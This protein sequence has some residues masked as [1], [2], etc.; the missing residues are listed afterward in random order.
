MIPDFDGASGWHSPAPVAPA[1][2]LHLQPPLINSTVEVGM[3][4]GYYPLGV[5]R[6]PASPGKL[7]E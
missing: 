3:E 2:G 7:T 1:T 5:D 6:D 4:C